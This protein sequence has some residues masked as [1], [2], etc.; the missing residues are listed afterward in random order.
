MIYMTNPFDSKINPFTLAFTDPY[1]KLPVPMK[2]RA[3]YRATPWPPKYDS[4]IK[5]NFT[6]SYLEFE[7]L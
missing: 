4:T 7:V 3:R 6:G 1:G 2:V 5:D